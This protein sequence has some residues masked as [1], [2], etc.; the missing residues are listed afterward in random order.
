MRAQ[1]P[2]C[3]EELDT[4]SEYIWQTAVGYDSPPG[5][6]HDD[7]CVTR[8]YKCKKGHV[9]KLSIRR[10]C[11]VE[12]CGWEGKERCSCHKMDKF[13]EWPE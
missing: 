11:P 2:E 12:G 4:R 7:N 13:D 1:C 9:V 6:D 8:A 3:G 5:H 10:R